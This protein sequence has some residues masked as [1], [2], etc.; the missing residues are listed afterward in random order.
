M[1]PFNDKIDDVDAYVRPLERVALGQ[2]WEKSDWATA[3]SLCLVG[4]AVSVFRRMP[5][6]EYMDYDTV[7]RAL[8][9]RF[10]LTGDGFHEKFCNVKPDNAESS[11]QFASRI[12]SYFDQWFEMCN[13]EKTYEKLCGR[14]VTKQ[15]LKC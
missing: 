10:R 12:M 11:K 7:K 3:L 5:A 8:L 9:Q 6:S 14:M 15:F 1:A 2:V 4:E 13:T